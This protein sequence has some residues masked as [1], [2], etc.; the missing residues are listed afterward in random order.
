MNYPRYDIGLYY[1]A[2]SVRIELTSYD[3]VEQ[4]LHCH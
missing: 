4:C 1:P 3:E 2:Y